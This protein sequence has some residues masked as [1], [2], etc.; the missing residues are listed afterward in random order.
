MR[1][2]FLGAGASYDFGLPLVW[3][4]T[5]VIRNYLTQEKLLKINA[6]RKSF[7]NPWS[8]DVVGSA[9]AA[10]LLRSSVD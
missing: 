2:L 8:D 1:G 10:W 6:R 4:F 9:A 3:E 7:G 5:S